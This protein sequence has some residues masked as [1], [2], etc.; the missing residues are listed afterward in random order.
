MRLAQITDRAAE[1]SEKYQL[2]EHL[3]N[4]SRKLSE[5]SV[6]AKRGAAVA[7]RT[8]LDNPKTSAAG[9]ILAAALIGGLLWWM[10]GDERRPVQRRKHANR[11][12]AGSERRRKSRAR[13]AAA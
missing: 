7:Y 6:A 1:L 9:V 11:V 3:D 13:A 5:V 4:A 8:A 12:R 2:P 10:F